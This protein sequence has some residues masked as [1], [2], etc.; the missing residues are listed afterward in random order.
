MMQYGHLVV[1]L[2]AQLRNVMVLSITGD[3]LKKS[4][5]AAA[6]YLSVSQDGDIYVSQ[7]K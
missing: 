4:N 2:C 1:T 7:R 3:I 6:G 5:T